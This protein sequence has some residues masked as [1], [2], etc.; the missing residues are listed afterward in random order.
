VQVLIEAT[1]HKEASIIRTL[2][3]GARA[4]D[5]L[6]CPFIRLLADIYHMNI[7]EPSL[8]DSLSE[9]MDYYPHLHISDDNRAYPGL[10]SLDFDPRPLVEGDKEL[11]VAKLK[12]IME[13]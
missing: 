1:N 7:E 2:K 6:D 8:L 9:Y 5:F 4:I 3:E 12:E 11:I 10:G 13:A